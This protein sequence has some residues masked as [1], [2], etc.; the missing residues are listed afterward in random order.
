MGA[1]PGT[2]VGDDRLAAK[3]IPAKNWVVTP[4]FNLQAE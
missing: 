4:E 1:I 2:Q 3:E